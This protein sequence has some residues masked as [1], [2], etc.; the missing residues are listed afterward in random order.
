MNYS[1]VCVYDPDHYVLGD[2]H[3]ATNVHIVS[4]M[5]RLGCTS[6]SEVT[7]VNVSKVSCAVA[8]R[9]CG[10]KCWLWAST[11]FNEHM[12]YKERAAYTP[13]IA[14]K[15]FYIRPLYV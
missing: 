14:P 13:G 3:A 1:T 2:A 11:T 8:G 10:N 12:D 15:I 5:L 6:L 4:V 9:G 7:V